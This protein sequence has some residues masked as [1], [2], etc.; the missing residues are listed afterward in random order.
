LACLN[1]NAMCDQWGRKTNRTAKEIK[2]YAVQFMRY[3]RKRKELLY[4]LP[5]KLKIATEIIR[6]YPKRK[7]ITFS[8]TTDSADTLSKMIGYEAC[9]YHSKMKG[10]KGMNGKIMSG[11]KARQDVEDRFK[12][13]D[14][15]VSC[16]VLCTAKALDMGADL[17]AIDLGLII[18]GTA[19]AVQG[20]QRYGRN[21]RYVPGKQT[22]IVELY[23]PDTQDERWLKSRQKKVPKGSI[24]WI[25]SIDD[26]Q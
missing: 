20:L 22:I 3:M 6:L 15:M 4:G 10:H 26:I 17:P 24:R 21:I 11:K 8:L 2:V 7:V 9:V 12:S 23:A 25:S 5:S 16:R 13:D 19:S 1:S 18:S 14:F